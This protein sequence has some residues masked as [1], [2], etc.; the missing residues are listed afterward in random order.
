MQELLAQPAC[1]PHPDTSAFGT[2]VVGGA[3][4]AMQGGL[5]STTSSFSRQVKKV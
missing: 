4:V 2:D 1:L 3:L 5:T